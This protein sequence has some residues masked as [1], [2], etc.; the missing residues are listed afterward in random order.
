MQR[1]KI[2]EVEGSVPDNTAKWT[3]MAIQNE[4]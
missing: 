3:E 1:E 2:R 4:P